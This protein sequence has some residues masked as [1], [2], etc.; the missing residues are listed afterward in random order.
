MIVD[1]CMWN[2][3]HKQKAM[4]EWMSDIVNGRAKEQEEE[5][6]EQKKWTQEWEN[7]REKEEE[8]KQTTFSTFLVWILH[9]T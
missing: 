3:H 5:E 4:S 8:R 2:Y 1:V 9:F 6:E 7:E